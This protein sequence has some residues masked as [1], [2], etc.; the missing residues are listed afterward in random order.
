MSSRALGIALLLLAHGCA[1]CEPGGEEPVDARS[2]DA[3]APLDAPVF[4]VTLAPTVVSFGDVCVDSVSAPIEVTLTHAG[5]APIERL[6]VMIAGLDSAA[7]R[8]EAS[9]CAGG[10]AIGATCSLSI[11][12]APSVAGRARASLEVRHPGGTRAA[13]LA[14]QGVLCDSSLSITP[15]PV[16]FEDLVVG[17]T[18]TSRRLTVRWLQPGGPTRLDVAIGGI[19]GASFGV[20]ADGCSG[21]VAA[22]ATECTIDV[23]CAPL[24]AGELMGLVEVTAVP[25]DRVTASLA[26]TAREPVADVAITPDMQDFGFVILGTRSAPVELTV[27]NIAPVPTGP[28]AV[29]ITSSVDGP[30]FELVRDGCAAGLAVGA[31]CP[32]EAR[33]TPASFGSQTASLDVLVG[34]RTRSA[35]LT[36][37]G[38]G[39]ESFVF[40]PSTHDFGPST[41]GAAAA[42]MRFSLWNPGGFPTGPVTVAIAGVHPSDFTIDRATSTCE[43]AVIAGAH[44]C[45]VDVVFAPTAIGA[46]SATLRA[47]AMPGGTATAS[48]LGTG[49]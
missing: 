29:T 49:L 21:D 32:L 42:P 47:Q 38:V 30:I 2:S 37:T 15:T 4:E 41:V 19:D 14:M 22:A 7:F 31:S 5:T 8:I 33:F 27:T 36:G 35:T 26:A 10:V 11:V 43:G 6:D 12:G 16:R 1:G 46:R 40:E 28:L 44:S 9:T 34:A 39:S 48:L 25:T 20:V 18:S 23:V 45:T 17:E 3:A 13:M 24:A